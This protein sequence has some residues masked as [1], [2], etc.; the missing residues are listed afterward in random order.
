MDKPVI[1]DT[2]P[3]VMDLEP[4]KYAYCTC[5]LSAAQP[6]CDGGHSGTSF[7]PQVFEILETRKAALCACKQ[8]ADAPF[9]DGEHKVCPTGD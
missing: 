3:V 9:C 5:G 7:T 2:K 6:F 4:G 8:T 1:A